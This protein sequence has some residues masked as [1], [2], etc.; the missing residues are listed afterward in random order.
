MPGSDDSDSD[1]FVREDV[2]AVG[3][4]LDKLD[5][6]AERLEHKDFDDLSSDEESTFSVDDEFIEPIM[7]DNGVRPA[8]GPRF[9]FVRD[10]V[11]PWMP[12]YERYHDGNNQ[13]ICGI[14]FF[15]KRQNQ[16]FL[17]S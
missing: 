3:E 15:S 6:L 11:Y 16:C 12:I 13:G 1:E 8:G 17:R 5:E 4:S 2:A 9:P 7:D 10:R 14:L